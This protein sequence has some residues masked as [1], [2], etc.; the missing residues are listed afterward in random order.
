MSISHFLPRGSSHFQ[1][2]LSVFVFLLL[3][4]ATTHAFAA[5]RSSTP[6]AAAVQQDIRVN[7]VHDYGDIMALADLRYD[8]FIECEE[9]AGDKYI[10]RRAFRKATA[11]IHQERTD[12]GAT[13]F[14]AKCSCSESSSDVGAGAAEL[15]PMEFAGAVTAAVDPVFLYVTDVVTSQHYRRRGVGNALMVAMEEEAARL[16]RES[17]QEYAC[18]FLHVF[19]DN[20]GAIQFYCNPKLGYQ[21]IDDSVDVLPMQIGLDNRNEKME[22]TVD[23]KR[24]T[25]NC[26][27][28]G[29]VLMIKKIAQDGTIY[30]DDIADDSWL[31]DEFEQQASN[32]DEFGKPPDWLLDDLESKATTANNEGPNTR[33]T[34]DHLLQDQQQQQRQSS[35]HHPPPKR[36]DPNPKEVQIIVLITLC[37]FLH[38]TKATMA[39]ALSLEEDELIITMQHL[40]RYPVLKQGQILCHWLKAKH[41]MNVEQTIQEVTDEDIVHVMQNVLQLTIPQQSQILSQWKAILAERSSLLF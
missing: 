19:P 26:E 38:D 15:S 21:I 27:T 6:A 35:S 14:L 37:E 4:P 18:L 5:T 3:T 29:Q 40:L 16:C 11:E 1:Q 28:E 31:L 9:N 24:L 39:D 30:R 8:E 17:Q 34:T 23:L 2:L 7:I 10:S 32:N 33:F 20:D 36:L 41:S 13:V 25:Q 22:V 12:E